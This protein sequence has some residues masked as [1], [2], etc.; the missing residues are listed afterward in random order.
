VLLRLTA[1]GDSNPD[2]FS[3]YSRCL[4]GLAADADV[5]RALRLFELRLLRALGYGLALDRDARTGEPLRAEYHYA[6]EIEHG[7]TAVD[8]PAAGAEVYSGAD[9]I[10]LRE[11]ALDAPAALKSAQRILARVL[12]VY[13]GDRPLRSR[14]VARD[15]VERGL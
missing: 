12:A 3:C 1:R 9:L 2:V 10:A 5:G 6:F 15:I 11:E 13:L 7:P 4:A 14:L 8:A